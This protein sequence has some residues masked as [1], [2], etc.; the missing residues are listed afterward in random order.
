[1]QSESNTTIDKLFNRLL[2]LRTKKQSERV[3]LTFSIA[4]YLVHL[5]LILLAYYGVIQSE[6][7]LLKSP[8]AA[9]YTP[10]SFILVYE[11]YLLIFFLTKSISFYIGKQYEIIT[12]IVIR[13]IFKDI[14]DLELA[15]KWFNTQSDLQFTYD[16]ITSLIL[17]L[18][19][20]FYYQNLKD[21]AETN[22]LSIG[23][24]ESKIKGFIR[25]KKTIAILLVPVLLGVA[26][27]TFADWL[28]AVGTD[29]GKGIVNFK[30]MNSI[31]FDE[32]FTILIVVDVLLLL[33][34]FFYS[35]KFHK[36]IRNSGFI[37]STILIKISFS[38]E[39][40]VN[41]LLIIGAVLFGFLIL[42]I[43]NKFENEGVM[44]KE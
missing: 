33:A 20:Y 29:F 23:L 17:F 2:S 42:L 16:A 9:I 3:I 22:D 38:T 4:S 35:D 5:G 15:S 43:H 25:L 14:G 7:K 21:R 39:G 27:Y 24:E 28:F 10:F 30:N 41:N 18:L 32:F 1:M 11:V 19:I 40:L 8:I 12:L 34:S 36:I 13:R 6:S 26:A 44:K 31:F 37:I